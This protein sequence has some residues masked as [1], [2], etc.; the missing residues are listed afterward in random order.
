MTPDEFLEIMR[1]LEKE[2]DYFI[3]NGMQESAKNILYEMEEL[4]ANYG[5]GE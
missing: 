3:S 2:Y 5:R 1:E 4:E